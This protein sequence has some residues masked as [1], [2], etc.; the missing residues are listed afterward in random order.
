MLGT[1]VILLHAIESGKK[2]G[3]CKSGDSIV[4]VHGS[5][6]GTSGSTNLLRVYTA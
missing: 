6:E 5:A 1:D 2:L 3:W 4:C